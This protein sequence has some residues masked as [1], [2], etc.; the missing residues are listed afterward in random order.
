M[1]ILF[2][3]HN[4]G[5]IA[6]VCDE[7]LYLRQGEQRF[8]GASQYHAMPGNDQRPLSLVDHVGCLVYFGRKI[9]L[10]GAVARQIDLVW[11]DIVK[12][13]S[14]L[15]ASFLLALQRSPLLALFFS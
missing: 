15:Q 13:G 10:A 4:F 6:T 14:L 3:S 1:G 2:V 5:V 12:L 11:I 9:V 7:T 8:L